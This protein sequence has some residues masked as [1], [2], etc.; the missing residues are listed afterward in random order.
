MAIKHIV[1]DTNTWVS[2][3]YN[4]QLDRLLELTFLK[5]L[6]IYTCPKQL[7]EITLVISRDK[8]AGKLKAPLSDYTDFCKRIAEV[9]E[10]DE[11]FDRLADP[12]DNYLIDMAYTVK[13]DHIVSS[14]VHL[15]E[16]KHVGRIQIISLTDFKKKL[17]LSY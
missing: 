6:T 17:S 8:F 12:K 14:D 3:F 13:A 1:F 15:L 4:A 10:I 16:L 7:E 2:Y 9:V 5:G 11:R